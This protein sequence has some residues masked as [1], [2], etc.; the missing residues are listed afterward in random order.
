MQRPAKKEYA[1]YYQGYIDAVPNGDL[2][3]IMEKQ[4][5]QLCEFFAH[6]NEEK[7]NYRYA[8]GKWT[9]K[10]VLGH[11]VDVE[12]IFLNRA[13]RISRGDKQNIPGFEQED[14][15]ANSNFSN[16]TLDEI[17][18]QFYLIRKSSVAIFK[19]LSEKMWG[20]SGVANNQKV[21]VRA[22]AY[23]MAGHVIHHMK[24]IAGKYLK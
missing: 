14:Y 4:N 7:A 23:I 10:E 20:L 8:E 22:I 2:L 1:A 3:V 15:V 19:S 17:V 16:L 21:T 5:T 18:E 6:V 13:L 12:L 11:V 9:L 24:I